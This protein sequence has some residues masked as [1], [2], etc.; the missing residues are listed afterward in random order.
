MEA[1]S[2]IEKSFLL[3]QDYWK[4]IGAKTTA[5]RWIMFY[6]VGKLIGCM[7]QR[8]DGRVPTVANGKTLTR[9]AALFVCLCCSATSAHY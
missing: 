6:W 8:D 4:I 9:T 7:W 5:E 3:A 2:P 1:S